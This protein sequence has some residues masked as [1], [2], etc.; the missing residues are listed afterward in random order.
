MCLNNPSSRL[1]YDVLMLQ[2]LRSFGG[3]DMTVTW[4]WHDGLVCLRAL[5]KERFVHP[6]G[7]HLT[8]IRVYNMWEEDGGSPELHSASGPFRILELVPPE[9]CMLNQ[10][11]IGA[12]KTFFTSE[13]C[14]RPTTRMPQR[15]V[16]L[17]ALKAWEMF[18]H[19]TSAVAPLRSLRE[20]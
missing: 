8:L 10:L 7:D 1:F 6:L 18:Q 4:R 2:L 13:P 3:G 14:A 19:G 5:I 16:F 11:R 20:C 12:R 17:N 15:S 9:T